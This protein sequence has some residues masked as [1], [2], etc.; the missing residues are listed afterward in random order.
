MQ[1]RS[2]IMIPIL[3]AEKKAQSRE[4]ACPKLQVEP[5]FQPGVL[6]VRVCVL[7]HHPHCSCEYNTVSGT[8]YNLIPRIVF[9]FF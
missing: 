8:S 5:G 4:V 7:Y 1:L 3:S 2:I 9:Y 6:D